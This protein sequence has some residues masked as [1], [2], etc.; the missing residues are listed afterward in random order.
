[1]NEFGDFYRGRKVLVTGDTGFKGAWL[2]HWLNMLG[3][4]VHG[5]G[6]EPETSPALCDVL[7]LD[8]K[9]S[10]CVIDIRDADA[11]RD[12]IH[13]LK[14]DVILHLA[15]Q[16]LVR[17]SYRMPLETM[18]SNI[19]GTAHVLDAVR[20]AGYTRDQPCSV[21]IVTSDKC[22]EN[23]ETGH[24]YSETDRVGG[25]DVYSMSKGAAELVVSAWRRSFFE[26]NG[27]SSVRVASCRAG[28]VIGGGDWAEDR[29]VPDC[30]RALTQELP[31]CVRNPNAVRPWQHVLEPLSGYLDVAH[32]MYRSEIDATAWNFGPG[33]RSERPVGALCDAILES[34]GAG[35]WVS[36]QNADAPHEANFLNLSIEMATR[37]LR[38][39]PVWGFDDA[40]AHTVQWYRHAF[41]TH[42][43][44]EALEAIT[45]KHVEQY[46]ASAAELGAAWARSG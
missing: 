20:G 29:I 8:Q 4:E 17:R 34:W 11:V 28:N 10:Q 46:C 33:K 37:E 21:V 30:I 1:M 32:R 2:S 19:M 14:P 18:A 9:T 38:W 13:A 12:Y 44:F 31:I 26:N 35:E 27:D 24:A 25:H 36:E 5:I 15:A 23:L 43:R 40:V 22:Y 6:L 39:C 3:A 7:S 41:D 16:S 45:T 42:H